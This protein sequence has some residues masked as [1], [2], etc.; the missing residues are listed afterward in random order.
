MIGQA[1]GFARG[2][3]PVTREENELF[4]A[5]MQKAREEDDEEKFNELLPKATREGWVML[6]PAATA[7]ELRH[8]VEAARQVAVNPKNRPLRDFQSRQAPK[9]A[10]FR[11]SI[12]R[13]KVAKGQGAVVEPA[14]A[15]DAGRPTFAERKNKGGRRNEKAADDERLMRLT[16]EHPGD[17]RA[18]EK[19]FLRELGGV[20]EKT[21][22]NRLYAARGRNR[23]LPE[24]PETRFSGLRV[25][26]KKFCSL[27]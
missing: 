11:P 1:R 10:R 13:R 15:D 4:D 9:P 25:R 6:T 19:A 24:L 14:G 27:Q 17:G 26:R 16:N 22:K 18:A 23:R 5:V 3:I 8:L 2:A 7:K 21:A 20:T 12:L